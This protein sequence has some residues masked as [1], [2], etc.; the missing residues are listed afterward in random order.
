MSPKLI[1]SCNPGENRSAVADWVELR[2][3]GDS[4]G[5]CTSAE[6][7]RSQAMLVEAD[8]H[9]AVTL[10][11]DIQ[12]LPTREQVDAEIIDGVAEELAEI[13]LSEIRYRSATLGALYPF[14]L[15]EDRY[16]WKLRRRNPATDRSIQAAR[17]CYLVCLLASGMRGSPL[18]SVAPLSLKQDMEKVFQRLSWINASSVLGGESHWLGFPRPD[19][20]GLLLSM[21]T[22]AAKMGLGEIKAKWP[23][24]VTWSSKDGGLDVIAWRRF[25]DT[26][27]GG[28]VLLGQVASGENWKGKSAKATTAIFRKF[29]ETE[30]SDNLIP[31]MF[32]PFVQHSEV[33][34]REPLDHDS[35][36]W[37]NAYVQEMD[38]GLI[39][40]RL[41][42]TELTATT[43]QTEENQRIWL[44]ETIPALVW[45]KK[46][47]ELVSV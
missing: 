20:S 35:F 31:A 13:A 21:Q 43:F 2:T 23:A 8:E 40:D 25:R 33:S 38:L 26:R 18:K 30:P 3:L 28:I 27:A 34:E 11:F 42:L 46:A 17:W 16:G 6:L 44:K 9:G 45:L 39:L 12:N 19:H 5:T 10:E 22:L 37:A 32:I 47:Q 36:A 14:D 15:E 24:G 7:V 29:W 1:E 41:R 4:F